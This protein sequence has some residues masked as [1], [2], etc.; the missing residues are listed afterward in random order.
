MHD[1]PANRGNV[2]HAAVGPAGVF[3]LDSRRLGGTVTV[4]QEGVTVRRLDDPELTYRHPGPEH[5]L[6]LGETHQRV[7]AA[8]RIKLWVTP[9]MV[10]RA[11]FPQRVAEDRCIY[12]HGGDLVSWLRSQPHTLA[13]SRVQQVADAV[14]AA[15]KPAN[16]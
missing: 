6:N 3:L 12:V 13:L 5:L 9:L 15:W 1:L 4:G 7:L 8:S 11:D 2:D 14:H 16:C 10:I